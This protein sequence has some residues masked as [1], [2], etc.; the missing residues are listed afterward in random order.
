MVCRRRDVQ[1]DSLILMKADVTS[2]ALPKD[3]F[4]PDTTQMLCGVVMLRSSN[5]V[6]LSQANA[7]VRTTTDVPKKWSADYESRHGKWSDPTAM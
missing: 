2:G 4:W 1:Q 6:R 3:P 5:Y 7:K